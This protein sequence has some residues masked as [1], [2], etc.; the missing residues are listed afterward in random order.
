MLRQNKRAFTLV[1]I[2]ITILIIAI[3][4]A[5]AVPNF[6]R[7]RAAARQKSC[8]QNLRQILNAK[9]QWAMDFKKSPTMIP[10]WP[11]DLVGEDRYIKGTVPTCPT[12]NAVYNVGMVSD[13][14]QCGD[15]AATT[16]P[17]M[18]GMPHVIDIPF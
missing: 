5:V 14:P 1:E 3:L 12:D 15:P 7:A 4:L 6:L 11:G 13:I 16:G 17:D 8:L 9:E 10:T 2:M 18:P